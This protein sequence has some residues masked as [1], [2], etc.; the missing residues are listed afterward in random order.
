MPYSDPS[1]QALKSKHD[2]K[3]IPSLVVYREDGSVV[4]AFGNKQFCR[5]DV[6][7]VGLH[8]MGGVKMVLDAWQKVS[9]VDTYNAQGGDVCRARSQKFLAR[10]F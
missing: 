8:A 2:V 7:E 3:T 5:H 4:D 1:I 6:T 10:W 9:H